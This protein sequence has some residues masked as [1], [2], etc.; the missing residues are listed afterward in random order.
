M[1]AVLLSIR[2]EWCEKIFNGEKTIEVRHSAPKIEPPF[3]ALVYCTSVK[4][5]PLDRYVEIHRATGGLIDYW[6]GK[7]IGSFVCD[8]VYDLF[9]WGLGVG[10]ANKDGDLLAADRIIKETCLTVEQIVDY[11]ERGKK[12]FKGNG[13]NGW[14]SGWRITE[15]KLFDRPRELSEFGVTR[16][17]QS[18][19]YVEEI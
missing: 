4:N 3:E 10:C 12:A 7:V 17:P 14:G 11:I 18:W 9:S 8:E 6:H 16:A 5:M 13:C 15:P 19:C 1:K 2:P